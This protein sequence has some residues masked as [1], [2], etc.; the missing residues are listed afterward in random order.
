MLLCYSSALRKSSLQQRENERR[1]FSKSKPAPVG[2]LCFLLCRA[3]E[4]PGA[5]ALPG[6][7]GLATALSTSE[8]DGGE[9]PTV[10][11]P[12]LCRVPLP[13]LYQVVP[14]RY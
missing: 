5:A 8:A 10:R 1:N 12:S 3:V 4:K 11:S 2:P 6:L 13:S 14:K 7:P 9:M